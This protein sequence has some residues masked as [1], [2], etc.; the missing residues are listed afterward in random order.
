VGTNGGGAKYVY[1][2]NSNGNGTYQAGIQITIDNSGRELATAD[3]NN[4]G[5]S[6]IAVAI[7]TAFE[8]SN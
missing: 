3:I 1:V 5:L 8:I 6:D 4:V 7:D 2:F